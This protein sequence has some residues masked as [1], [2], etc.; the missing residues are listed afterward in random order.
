[1]ILNRNFRAYPLLIL[2]LTTM[3]SVAC[4]KE[5]DSNGN[6]FIMERLVQL[7]SELVE[8]SGI[9]EFDSLIWFINDSGNSPLLYGYSME[10][11]AINRTAFVKG[12]VDADWEDITQ[13][14][15]YIFIGDF[16]NN[17]S[18]NRKDL[19]I[20][21]VDKGQLAA[22]TDTVVPEVITF[23][24]EDQTDFTSLPQEEVTFD[25]EAFI[26]TEDSLI[27]FTKDW[28]NRVTRLYT[29]P[30]KPG[31]YSAKYRKQWN[32]NG[33]I[34]A[35]AWSEKSK[36]LYLLGY[37]P[38]IPFLCLFSGFSA[39]H[40]SYSGDSRTDFPDF[41]GTQTEG[42]LIRTDGSLLV[43][44]EGNE[45]LNSMQSLFIIKKP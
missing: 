15:K 16:G 27:L 5:E 45:S 3:I 26:S 10:K 30:A 24:Y 25:C 28:K 19:R 4:I 31:D 18:G 41:M 8:N 29:I 11:K 42:L 14:R 17:A 32:I 38:Y 12:A 22:K 39:D 9:V 13:N 6:S 1:M 2:S 7:P 21:V 36:S 43:S 44:C 35:A 23:R 20:Y 34:T 33:L 40:M 37:T